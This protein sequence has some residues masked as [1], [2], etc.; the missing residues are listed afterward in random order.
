MISFVRGI[1]IIKEP[2]RAVVDVQ[3]VGY[4]LA[5]SLNTYGQLSA[6]GK[7]V[8]LFT[9]LY[10]RED[11]LDLFGFADEAERRVFELLIGVSGIGPNSAQTIL[12]GMSVGDLQAA[13]F[14]GRLA[15][16]T[17]IKGIG[18]KTAERML[19]DL[20]DKIGA[21]DLGGDSGA[22]G[23]SSGASEEAVLALS[24]LGFTA[25]AARQAVNKAAKKHGG[26]LS[27]QQLIKRALQER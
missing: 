8:R 1:L 11:R 6:A 16:L 25:A 7:E 19:I 2:T 14:H 24:A 17:S 5:I 12:S 22:D 21:A 3:G 10:V 9:Y 27:V 4:G 20:K 26:E 15:E 18:K 13:V 23:E